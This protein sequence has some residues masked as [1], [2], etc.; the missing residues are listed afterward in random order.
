MPHASRTAALTLATASLLLSACGSEPL[1]PASGLS[2]DAATAVQSADAP[3]AAYPT[4]SASAKQE[5]FNPFADR[6]GPAPGGRE[7]IDNPSKAEVL[8]TGPLSEMAWGAQDAPVTIVKYASL[9]CPYCKK[10]HA[11]VFPELKREYIDTGKVR[12]IIREFP[13]GKT[14]GNATIALRCAS[15]DRY[16]ELYGKFLAQQASWVSQEVRFDPIFAV[17]AQVGVK[18]AE[19]DA[20]L[21]NQQ[22]VDGLK[23]VKERGRKLGVIG[24]PNFFVDGKLIK[25]VLTMGDIRALVDPLVAAH[26][27][28]QPQ[29]GSS[30]GP[31]PGS[32]TG[33]PAAATTGM[34][35]PEAAAAPGKS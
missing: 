14:S 26:A 24:T 32:Q 4:T 20:C 16:L 30:A 5:A 23:W 10:F 19:F 11:E 25:K 33:S 8:Q 1:L 28:S 13:I 27:G 12:Y 35:L 6:S 22:L 31:P 17:A 21:Q 3:G 2:K 7:V 34:P 15:P 29:A 9:T 18:R